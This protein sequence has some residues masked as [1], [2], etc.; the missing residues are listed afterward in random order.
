ELVHLKT[1]R[2]LFVSQ[3]YGVLD[4]VLLQKRFDQWRAILIHRNTDEYNTFALQL[5]IHSVE[6]RDLLNAG[7]APGRPEVQ[8][9]NLAGKRCRVEACAIK[10]R[11]R[12]PGKLCR[13]GAGNRWSRGWSPRCAFLQ[14]CQVLLGI[15]CQPREAGDYSLLRIENGVVGNRDR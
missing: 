3:R 14:K 4:W 1:L 12:Q 13:C 7:N 8:Y 11:Q 10:R 2:D 15:A 5:A 6:A 9:D